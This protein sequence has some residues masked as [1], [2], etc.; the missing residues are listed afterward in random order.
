MQLRD[1]RPIDLI[2]YEY[3]HGFESC[4]EAYSSLIQMRLEKTQHMT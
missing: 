3:A 2:V 1:H 4:G